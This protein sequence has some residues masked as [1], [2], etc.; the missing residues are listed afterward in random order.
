M[1]DTDAI[2]Q[3]AIELAAL[4]GRLAAVVVWCV[5]HKGECLADN[6]VQLA[7]AE[8]VLAESDART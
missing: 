8:K 7:I 2:E 4:T 3:I 6:P 1:N 5:E